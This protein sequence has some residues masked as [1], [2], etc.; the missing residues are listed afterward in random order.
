MDE[1]RYDS[2]AQA[3]RLTAAAMAATAA[4][5]VFSSGLHLTLEHQQALGWML[6]GALYLMSL[7]EHRMG[8]VFRILFLS[9]GAFIS[10]RYLVFRTTETVFFT[11]PVDFVFMMLLYLSELY[12][13]TIHLLGMFVNVWRMRRQPVPLPQDQSL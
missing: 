9:L 11:G 10:L 8:M 12:G 5:A 1:A 13:I 3:G 6:L 4:L 2:S 7:V